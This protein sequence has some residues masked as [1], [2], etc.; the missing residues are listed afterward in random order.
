[1]RI[2]ISSFF[3]SHTISQHYCKINI[4]SVQIFRNKYTLI[5]NY[6]RSTTQCCKF[7]FIALMVYQTLYQ[8]HEVSKYSLIHSHLQAVKNRPDLLSFS[9]RKLPLKASKQEQHKDVFTD[10]SNYPVSTLSI[11]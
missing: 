3:T 2:S 9:T 5:Q 6:L 8:T 4:D 1:M 10:A 7:T 11:Q